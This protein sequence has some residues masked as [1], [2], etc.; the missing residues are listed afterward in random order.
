MYDNRFPGPLPLAV[1]PNVPEPWGVA[2]VSTGSE[3]PRVTRS[4]RLN[5]LW[6][7]ALLC[8]A[9]RSFGERW[10]TYLE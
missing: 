2:D 7:S 8:V 10:G 6:F 1:L 4:L 5:E 9:R 3:L